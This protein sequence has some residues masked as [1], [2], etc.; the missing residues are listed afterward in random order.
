MTEGGLGDSCGYQCAQRQLLLLSTDN[1]GG[2]RLPPL[3]VARCSLHGAL[4]HVNN[5]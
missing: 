1:P 2:Q 3:H 4:L 5:K